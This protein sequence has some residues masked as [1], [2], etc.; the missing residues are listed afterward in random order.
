LFEI[1]Y[2]LR[3]VPHEWKVSKTIPIYKNK[4]LPKNV[5]SNR[6]NANLCLTSK[7]FEKLILKG[8]LE[9]LDQNDVAITRQA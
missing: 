4:G 9:I 3:Q 5:E 2:N 1:I 8:I 7:I 6:P